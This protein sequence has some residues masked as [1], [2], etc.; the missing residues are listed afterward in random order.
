M[1]ALILGVNRSIV[2]YTFKIFFN[3]RLPLMANH[4]S[5]HRIFL[6]L[7]KYFAFAISKSIQECPMTCFSPY[8]QQH[9]PHG[10][11]NVLSSRLR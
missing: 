5:H 6:V 2:K 3:I 11:I 4:F 8:I 1:V 7:K 9:I 10:I